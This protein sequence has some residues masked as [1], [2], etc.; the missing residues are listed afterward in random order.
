MLGVVSC[1]LARFN[2]VQEFDSF[3]P[4]VCVTLWCYPLT[5]VVSSDG[6]CPSFVFPG[7]SFNI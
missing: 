1:D 4:L 6:L 2:G 5:K 7:G 3:S